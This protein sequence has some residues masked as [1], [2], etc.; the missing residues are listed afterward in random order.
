MG[1]QPTPD[2][3]RRID[4][5]LYVLLRPYVVHDRETSAHV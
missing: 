4:A 3:A 5:N 1:G 2:S